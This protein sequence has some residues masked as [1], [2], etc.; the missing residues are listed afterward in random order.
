MAAVKESL[1][2]DTCPAPAGVY[3]PRRPVVSPLH[4]LLTDHFEREHGRRQRVIRLI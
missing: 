1:A 3:H 4:R 2:R